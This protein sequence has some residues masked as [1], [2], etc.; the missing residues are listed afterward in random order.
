MFLL[1]WAKKIDEFLFD[2]YSRIRGRIDELKIPQQ[3]KISIAPQQGSNPLNSVTEALNTG[4]TTIASLKEGERF[5]FFSMRVV[6]NFLV[7][8]SLYCVVATFG[9][10]MYQEVA[11]KYRT[12]Q[13]ISYILAGDPTPTPRPGGGLLGSR[14]NTTYE[15]RPSD[16]EFGVV[17]PKIGAN[18]NV[19][20]NV[21]PGNYDQYMDALKH[22][23]AHA[24]GTG[25][26]GVDSPNKN[27]YLFAHSTD[28]PW[29]VGRYNA[30]FYLV[31]ELEPGDEIDLFFNGVR[32]VYIVEEKKVVDPKD[33]HYLTEPSSEEQLI[34]QTCW[35]PGTTLQRLLVI[36][37]PKKI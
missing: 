8:F 21:D 2:R 18:A 6:G 1:T 37:K 24:A 11:Y 29:N 10:V 22:G 33:L 27:I 14:T 30:I 28:F 13:G 23:V 34:L 25:L 35:P 16:T 4:T 9:P 19:I 12:A 20:A 7:L 5:K 31:K 3:P 36:A 17:I 32:H 26:P 15:L